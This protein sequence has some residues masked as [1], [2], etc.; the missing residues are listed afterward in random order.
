VSKVIATDSRQFDVELDSGVYGLLVCQKAC[1][2]LMNYISCQISTSDTKIKIVATVN[3]DCGKSTS[4]L[5]G[6]LMDEMID[7]AL[8][9]TISAKTESVRN[10]ILSN[11]F[12]NTKLIG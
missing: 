2:A 3:S 11:A 7:Y 6:L 8:R 5:K 10:I 9:E 12:S 1:Y 4:E